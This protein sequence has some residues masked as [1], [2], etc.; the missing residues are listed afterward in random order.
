MNQA[1]TVLLGAIAGATIFLGLPVARLRGLGAH[2][3]GRR[4]R[5]PAGPCL[6]QSHG[7]QPPETWNGRS[8]PTVPVAGDRHR[9]WT[10]QP[11]RRAGDRRVRPRWRHR[12]HRC[13]GGRLR[14]PQHH[15]RIR[16]RRPHDDRL[17]AGPLGFSGSRRTNRRWAYFCRDVD[18]L[19]GKLSLLLGR[20]SG[21]RG[22]RAALRAERAVQ[23]GPQAQF[24]ACVRLGPAVRLPDRVCDRP[25]ADRRERPLAGVVEVGRTVPVGFDVLPI[26]VAP[27]EEALLD[28]EQAVQGVLHLAVVAKRL[29]DVVGHRLN[30]PSELSPNPRRHSLHTVP[31]HLLESP[32]DP[33]GGLQ[34]AL[35][36]IPTPVL[37]PKGGLLLLNSVARAV[38]HAQLPFLAYWLPRVRKVAI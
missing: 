16:D 7:V 24:P 5:R 30:H 26:G 33:V 15:R 32:E 35:E 19:P 37:P 10:A 9:A 1:T 6:L 20:L 8:K 22:R 18:R 23:P 12:L 11:L 38:N 21:S 36:D 13:A 4:Y 27:P 34:H 3:R 29:L 2:L 17:E 14:A 25:C 28:L 31:V